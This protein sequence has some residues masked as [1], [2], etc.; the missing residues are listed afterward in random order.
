MG[1]DSHV[2]LSVDLKRLNLM[3]KHE[4]YMLRNQDDIAPKLGGVTVINKLDTTINF[5]KFLR[6]KKV[7]Y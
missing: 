1:Y 4:V 7:V 6:R 2:C 5:I 3:V